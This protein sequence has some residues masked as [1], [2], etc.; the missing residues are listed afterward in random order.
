MKEAAHPSLDIV[1]L[2]PSYTSLSIPRGPSVVR[3]VSATAWHALIFEMI[4]DLPCDVSVPSRRRIIC[5]WNALFMTLALEARAGASKRALDVRKR[6]EQSIDAKLVDRF[7]GESD[8]PF[9]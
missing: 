7:F 1:T 9:F 2:W 8:F 4:C 5:G 6:R 3:T